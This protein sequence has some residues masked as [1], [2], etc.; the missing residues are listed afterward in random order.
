MIRCVKKK[1]QKNL[2]GDVEIGGVRGISRGA[3]DGDMVILSGDSGRVL[4]SAAVIDSLDNDNGNSG[5]SGGCGCCC[6]G[7]DGGGG[8]GGCG[9][10]GG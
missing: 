5:G 3:K 10:C 4:P 6:G 9:G 2:N 1:K 7:G 8:C